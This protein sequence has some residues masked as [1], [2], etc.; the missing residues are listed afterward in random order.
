MLSQLARTYS[1]RG[2][3]DTANEY[4]DD[5]AE[6]VINKSSRG[7]VYYLLERG[8]TSRSSGDLRQARSSFND[9]F[10]I[11]QRIQNDYLS[12]D[13]AHMM[14]VVEPLAKQHQWHVI[15]LEI[16]EQ[17]ASQRARGWLGTL[18]NNMGW[19][20]FDQGE[21]VSALTVFEKGVEFRRQ[22]GE[23]RR[24]QIAQWAVAR[25]LRA[26]GRLPEAL[27]IQ[28]KLLRQREAQ[29]QV[30]DGYVVE[31][32]AEIY[33]LQ[34][35]KAAPTYFRRAY[36]LLITDAYL[37]EHETERLERLKALSGG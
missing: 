24:E 25:T 19:T 36:R 1:L 7:W 6:A 5:A 15:A 21:Y 12:V 11:A 35:N 16:A 29:G 32:I 8:R 34:G 17:S 10:M 31:E 3:Y 23:Q 18:Y 27:A 20:Y 37:V 4:L 13:A 33:L 9:A 14:G 28:E 22:Q 30:A 2:E 26:L